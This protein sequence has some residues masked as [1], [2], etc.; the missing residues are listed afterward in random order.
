MIKVSKQ[1]AF[2]IRQ[3]IKKGYQTRTIAQI[4]DRDVLEMHQYIKD[5]V[6]KEPEAAPPRRAPR[7]IPRYDDPR[8]AEIGSRMLLSALVKYFE[9]HRTRNP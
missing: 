5:M 7:G 3:L 6:K 4:L 8:S 1:E 2:T 9:K